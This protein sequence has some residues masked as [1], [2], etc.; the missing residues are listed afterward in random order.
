MRRIT[1]VNDLRLLG[2]VLFVGA[3]PDDEVFCAGGIMAACVRAGQRVGGVIATRGEEGSVDEGRWPKAS[4]GEIRMR[5]TEASLDVIGVGELRW[6]EY[7]DGQC[8]MA[9]EAEAASALWQEIDRF[10]PDTILTFGPDGLT[11]HPD[12][13]AVGRWTQLATKG[14]KVQVLWVAVEREQYE[15]LRPVDE[16]ANVFFIDMPAL[17]EASACVI[18]L[19]LPADLTSLKRQAFE[20]EE[21]QFEALLAAKPFDKPGAGLAREC[22]IEAKGRK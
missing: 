4:L 14:M 2:D 15:E 18:D 20:Q 9:D 6:L 13:Q 19:P 12:H 8:A 7:R 16:A 11:W 21:S 5:E 17:V 1:N 10:K 3:H 22:F